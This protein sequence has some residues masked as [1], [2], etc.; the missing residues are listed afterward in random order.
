M[1]FSTVVVGAFAAVA[2]A[3]SSGSSTTTVTQTSV[4]SV[5]QTYSLTPAQSSV[6]SCYNRC[7][8]ADVGCLAKCNPV[9]NPSDDMVNKTHNCINDCDKGNG[10]ETDIQNF[11]NCQNKCISDFYYDDKNGGVPQS[12]SNGASTTGSSEATTSGT[13]SGSAATTA[14]TTLTNSEGSATA[15]LSSAASTATETGAAAQLFG[16]SVALL[17]AVAAALAL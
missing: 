17:G 9:P 14:V 1:R 2:S 6:I 5:T 16:S 4:E 8:Q 13:A 15:T 11:T 7:D 3:Q 10:T 12:G